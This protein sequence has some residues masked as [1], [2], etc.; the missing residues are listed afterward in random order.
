M[1]NAQQPRPNR[2]FT[3]EQ[4]PTSQQPMF[5]DVSSPM[6]KQHPNSTYKWCGQPSCKCFEWENQEWNNKKRPF[7]GA[8]TY[9]KAPHV[10]TTTE[11]SFGPP[12][13]TMSFPS[14]NWTAPDPQTVR[15]EE[16]LQALERSKAGLDARLDS[17]ENKILARIAADNALTGRLT[18]LEVKTANL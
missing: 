13:T 16:R 12:K 3:G 1:F 5:T 7:S 11:V 10:A 18:S 2:V 9:P 17:L 15:F 4:C 6:S 14:A 8:A